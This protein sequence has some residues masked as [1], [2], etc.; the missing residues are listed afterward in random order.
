MNYMRVVLCA[1][2]AVGLLVCSFGLT[3]QTSTTPTVDPKVK[4]VLEPLAMAEVFKLDAGMKAFRIVPLD[5]G[6]CTLETLGERDVIAIA[7]AEYD[8]S[9]RADMR[10]AILLMVAAPGWYRDGEYRAGLVTWQWVPGPEWAQMFAA[11]VETI[12]QIRPVDG[13]VPVFISGPASTCTGADGKPVP[14]SFRDPVAP[15]GGEALC[16]RA[17]GKTVPVTDLAF[18]IGGFTYRSSDATA[19]V[20]LKKARIPYIPLGGGVHRVVPFREG[21]NLVGS[22][23]GISL[24]ITASNDFIR[25]PLTTMQLMHSFLTGG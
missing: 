16:Y 3:A 2:T 5:L 14:G 8:P 24:H 10:R 7:V 13:Q 23:F 22:M 6:D 4:A 17:T 15:P 9:R 20:D 12:T 1:W 19:G 11:Y 25:I 18:D 21:V